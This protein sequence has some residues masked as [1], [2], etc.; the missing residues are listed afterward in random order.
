MLVI[1]SSGDIIAGNSGIILLLIP[2][3][4]E[5][6]VFRQRLSVDLAYA[7][8]YDCVSILGYAPLLTRKSI[9]DGGYVL[10]LVFVTLSE[11]YIALPLWDISRLRYR[12]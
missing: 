12:S 5:L 6:D 9:L 1:V 7:L 8:G 3:R 2:C 11:I 10:E 4:E